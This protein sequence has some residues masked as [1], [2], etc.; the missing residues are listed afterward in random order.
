MWYLYAAGIVFLAA[1][2]LVTM[3]G[4]GQTRSFATLPALPLD[5]LTWRGY[6]GKHRG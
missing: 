6:V 2:G 1:I 3:T 4:I 5:K